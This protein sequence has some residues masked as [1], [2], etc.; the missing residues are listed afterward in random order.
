MHSFLSFFFAPFLH[1]DS[2]DVNMMNGALGSTLDNVNNGEMNWGEPGS[3]NTCV[4][5][6]ELPSCLRLLFLVS[7]FPN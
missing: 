7:A 4:S 3:P 2:W 6:N 1:S 5:R